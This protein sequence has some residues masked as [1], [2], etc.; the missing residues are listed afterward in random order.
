MAHILIVDDE[1]GDRLFG[2]AALERAGHELLF[3]SSGDVALRAF[4]R[5]DI[6]LVITDLV[7]PNTNGILLIE[8]ILAEDDG[9]LIIAVSGVSPEQLERAE[10][11]GARRTLRKPYSAAELVRIVTETLDGH[12]PP[13]HD[14]WRYTG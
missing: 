10:A 6:D 2:R 5:N 14:H 11:L 4:Q 1:E 3:A 12:R 8:Q 13:P 9:A 7:M